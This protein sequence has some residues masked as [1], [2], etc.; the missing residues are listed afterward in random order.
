MVVSSQIKA[1]LK[2][3]GMRTSKELLEALS[4]GIQEQLDAATMKALLD[5]R[6]TVRPEDLTT[7][8]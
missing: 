1:Y 6:K 7:G 3:K 8:E 5:K 2:S 4:A